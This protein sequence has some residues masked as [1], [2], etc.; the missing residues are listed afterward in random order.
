[1]NENHARTLKHGAYRADIPIGRLAS[2][3][4]GQLDVDRHNT[5]QFLAEHRAK[6][7]FGVALQC[8]R[9]VGSGDVHDHTSLHRNRRAAGN[10]P[11]SQAG[12]EH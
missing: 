9:D 12:C 10:Q 5:L 11:I 1:M 7:P 3:F 8:C 6:A 2:I 4:S